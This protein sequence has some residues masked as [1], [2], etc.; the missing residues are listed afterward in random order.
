MFHYA[1]FIYIEV[2]FQ[3]SFQ[4]LVFALIWPGHLVP[5]LFEVK[6]PFCMFSKVYI[7]FEMGLWPNCKLIIGLICI[8]NFEVIT[9]RF[10]RLWLNWNIQKVDIAQ[11]STKKKWSG[12]SQK[13][14][15]WIAYMFLVC[16]FVCNSWSFTLL[17]IQHNVVC[18][19]SIWRQLPIKIKKS[20][21]TKKWT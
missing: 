12:F 3:I 21:P 16:E 8:E 1:S 18:Y 5:D 9:L 7:W 20:L 13:G 17:L 14:L 10:Y 15:C 11:N 2:V 6:I 4:I 19:T